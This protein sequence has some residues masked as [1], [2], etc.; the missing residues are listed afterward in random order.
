MNNKTLSLV[1]VA[2]LAFGASVA[3]AYT[4]APTPPPGHPAGHG[5]IQLSDYD[6]IDSGEYAGNYRYVYDLYNDTSTY[7]R[8]ANLYFDASDIQNVYNYGGYDRVAHVWTAEPAGTPRPSMG[9]IDHN[10]FPSYWVTKPDFTEGWEQ[11]KDLLDLQSSNIYSADA[12]PAAPNQPFYMDNEWHA[13]GEYVGGGIFTFRTGN[14]DETG[15][16][17]NSDNNLLDPTR[18]SPGLAMTFVIYHPSPVGTANIAFGINQGVG[19]LVDGPHLAVYPD[20]DVDRDGDV[21]VDDIDALCDFLRG[22]DPVTGYRYDLSDDGEAPNEGGG[23]ADIL[24]LDYLI[25]FRVET[26]AGNGTEYGDFNLDGVIDTTDLA[27]LALNFGDGSWGWNDG[28]GNG[29]ID[30]NI[31]TTDLAMLAMFFG[32]GETDV[33]PEPAT[34]SLLAIGGAVALIRR[35]K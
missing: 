32:F 24:D 18:F 22:E 14:F 20:G 10:R 23:V 21:D 11:P 31:D 28:N 35:K 1:L 16:Y 3:S 29:Y 25:R 15:I 12:R 2:A 33:V 4:T 30:T 34:M 19:G 13:G 26:T 7:L 8:Q 6:F 27:R 9:Y 5:W 17:W